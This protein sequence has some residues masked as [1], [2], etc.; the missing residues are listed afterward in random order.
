MLRMM[1]ILL[2]CGLSSSAFA[3]TCSLQE[4]I[5]DTAPILVYGEVT[6]RTATDD[7][8]GSAIYRFFSGGNRGDRMEGSNTAEI[9]VN[10]LI[11]GDVGDVISVTASL[12]NG[13]NGGFRFPKGPIVLGAYRTSSGEL[14]ADFCGYFGLSGPRAAEIP[15]DDTL[16]PGS[17]IS[18][19][20]GMLVVGWKTS[21]RF[22]ELYKASAGTLANDRSTLSEID[23]LLKELGDQERR[24]KVWKEVFTQSHSADDGAMIAE[25]FLAQRQYDLA[26]SY[27]TDPEISESPLAQRIANTVAM[28][29]GL[30]ADPVRAELSG[31]YFTKPINLVKADFSGRTIRDFRASHIEARDVDFSNTDM[32]NVSLEGNLS[33]ARFNDSRIANVTIH[34]DAANTTFTGAKVSGRRE[35]SMVF[36]SPGL[37]LRRGG[38]NADFSMIS[39]SGISLQGDFTD[40]SFNDIEIDELVLSGAD[41]TNATF[42]GAK[43]GHL[44]VF[45]TILDGV[46][47]TAAKSIGKIGWR[48][49][50]IDC[51]TRLYG[52]RTA[53]EA[54][55]SHDMARLIGGDQC[56]QGGVT[57]EANVAIGCDIACLN[58]L[59]EH[60]GRRIEIW[61]TQ[62]TLAGAQEYVLGASFPGRGLCSEEAHKLTRSLEEKSRNR[63]DEL[64]A[65]SDFCPVA[66]PGS[67][68]KGPVFSDLERRMQEDVHPIMRGKGVKSINPLYRDLERFKYLDLVE[69]KNVAIPLLIEFLKT[70]S[71]YRSSVLAMVP[72]E[73]SPLGDELIA[74]ILKE[75]EKDGFKGDSNMAALF[76]QTAY[77]NPEM[78]TAVL[79]ALEV[80]P[81]IRQ[82]PAY[83]AFLKMHERYKPQQ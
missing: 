9:R 55:K 63:I 32:T 18:S 79:N 17:D 2:A 83:Q 28:I 73:V 65:S 57:E 20:Y 34:A 36:D 1:T 40:A 80:N 81:S 10:K 16:T 50:K 61:T 74:L 64:M 23:A 5:Q 15:W 3:H 13:A 52:G 19:R 22:I 47:L 54:S 7:G 45:N 38:R 44:I 37:N 48:E 60:P 53:F 67:F 30:P 51:G 42:N 75:M 6:S 77:Q 31:Q 76:A 4:G 12:D 82:K 35:S 8:V 68:F 27:A 29:K 69:R 39:G 49:V 58:S 56:G 72:E 11:K 26:L 66:V 24:V 43:I 25:A 71:E 70:D 78:R 14:R 33:G 62:G 41:L 46:D 21:K 59:I